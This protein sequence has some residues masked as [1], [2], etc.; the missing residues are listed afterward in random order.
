[1]NLLSHRTGR[2]ALFAA[3]YFS[4]GAPIGLVWWALPTL[5]RIEGVDL[6]RITGLTA[7]LVLPWTLKFLWAPLVDSLRTPRW[8]F[9]AW[10][11]TAQVCMGVTI[12]PLLWIDPVAHFEW[13]RV[14]LLVHAFTAAT[15]DV[16]IDAL[17]INVV[18][19]SERGALNGSMQAGMLIGRSAF[20]GGAILVSHWLG[21]EWIL[22][23]LVACIWSSLALVLVSREPADLLARRNPFSGFVTHARSAA[24]RR[25]TWLGLGFALLGA[26]AFES[27]GQLVGPYL[28]DRGVAQATI[29]AFFGLA[30]VGAT[31]TGGLVGGR[32]SDRWGRARSVA[33]FLLGFVAT[34]ALLGTL[35]VMGG[36]VPHAVLLT[37][38]TILYGFIGLFTASSYALFMDLT[39]PRLGGTQF[40]TYMSATN[41]CESW[42]GWTGG[43]IAG[44]AGYG[45]SFLAMCA[46][47]LL[48]LPLLRRLGRHRVTGH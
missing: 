47:S 2:T 30:V 38:F 22:A 29:G 19:A 44:R 35:D 11:A 10:I 31:V 26:A 4:E 48:S 16:A 20:G 25:E 42:S 13:W 9:R 39:D 12:L 14:C 41:A 1:M 24:R 40:S 32:L 43:Q 6:R 17:A 46:V 7:T 33:Y 3:L 23:A 21:R 18:P 37:G 15:Q 28:V 34:I 8:G 27:A 5:L 36:S 45:V